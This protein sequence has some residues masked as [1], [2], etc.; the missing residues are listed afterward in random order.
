MTMEMSLATFRLVDCKLLR[1]PQWL[2]CLKKVN[3]Y[4]VHL[5]TEFYNFL[6]YGNIQKIIVHKVNCYPFFNTLLNYRDLIDHLRSRDI[7]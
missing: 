2:W 3:D 6:Q 1:F 7:K 5:A 4:N